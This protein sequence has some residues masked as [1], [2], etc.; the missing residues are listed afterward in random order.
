MNQIHIVNFEVKIIAIGLKLSKKIDSGFSNSCRVEWIE[1]IVKQTLKSRF[2]SNPNSYFFM[3]FSLNTCNM[4]SHLIQHQQ[5]MKTHRLG[6]DTY[7]IFNNLY[8]VFHLYLIGVIYD[9]QYTNQ[10]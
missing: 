5:F 8:R 7:F 10:F 1:Y 4:F 6:C 3:G 2:F 9:E